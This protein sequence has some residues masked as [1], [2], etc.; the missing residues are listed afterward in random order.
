MKLQIELPSLILLNATQGSGKSHLIRYL[1]H[2]NRKKFDYGIIFCNT[3]FEADSFDYIDK[4]FVHPEYNP[5][6]LSNLMKIQAK[7]V[8]EGVI[9]QA[10]V[11]FDDCIQASQFQCPNLKQLCTQLRHFHITVIFATQYTN[12]LPTWMR[13]NA[14]DVIIFKTTSKSNLIALYESYGQEY[15]NFND[16]KNYIMEN[17]GNYKFIYYDKR[18]A[19]ENIEQTYKIMICP[20]KIPKFKLKARKLLSE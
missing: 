12:L 11:V 20:S 9:K 5:E 15:G 13:A 1:M 14:M 6:V 18:H 4:K 7:L 17:L 8:E 3:H 19:N 16:F 10:Y 2:M